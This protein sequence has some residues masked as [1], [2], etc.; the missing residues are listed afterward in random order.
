MRIYSLFFLALAMST[1]AF[2]ASL[3]K[4]ADSAERV[5]WWRALRIGALFGTIEGLT[6]LLGWALG[7]MASVYVAQWDHWIAFV[8]LVGLGG[9]MVVDTQRRQVPCEDCSCKLSKRWWTLP[10]LALATS[11]DALIVGVSL[12]FA[13]VNIGYAALAIGLT[14]AVMVTF[15]VVLGGMAGRFIGKKAELFGGLML[16]AIGTSILYQHLSQ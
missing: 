13:G 6:P 15:G 1:D 2:A 14:T 9:K 11:L 12:S 7:S 16:I 3:A 8:L 10:L 4:G 5:S